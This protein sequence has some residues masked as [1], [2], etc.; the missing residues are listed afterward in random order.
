MPE[1][2]STLSITYKLKA[3]A[4]T[5]AQYQC[6]ALYTTEGEVTNCAANATAVAGILD[7]TTL[8]AEAVGN[9]QI[10]GVGKVLVASA[11]AIGDLVYVADNSGRVAKFVAGTTP[12]GVCIVGR[13]LRAGTNANDVI[14]FQI[15]L[16]NYHS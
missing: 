2:H 16:M 13:A 9:F 15:I 5:L 12:S 6:A 4:T 1:M 11:V 14:T 7:D 3:S 10:A 8:A